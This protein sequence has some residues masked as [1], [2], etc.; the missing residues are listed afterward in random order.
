MFFFIG[1]VSKRV[2]ETHKKR[3]EEIAK[4]SKNPVVIE[5]PEIHPK[6]KV[7]YWE[8]WWKNK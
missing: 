8:P 2:K 7:E 5:T 4:F 3:M 6:N 1:E